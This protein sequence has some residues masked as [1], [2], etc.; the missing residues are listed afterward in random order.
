MLYLEKKRNRAEEEYHIVRE[1]ENMYSISQKY[2]IKL[3]K[4]YK[5]NDMEE[6]TQPK[7]GQRLVL[8]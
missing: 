1:N 7:V 5:H 2:G 6:G 3:R 8:R 4:L